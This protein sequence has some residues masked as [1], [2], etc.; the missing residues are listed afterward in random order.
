[1]LILILNINVSQ[2][3]TYFEMISS[4]LKYDQFF[5]HSTNCCKIQNI[6]LPFQNSSSHS[7][8]SFQIS[9]SSVAVLQHPID[10]KAIYRLKVAENTEIAASS[11]QFSL[12]R[13]YQI[14]YNHSPFRS[15]N[16]TCRI[17]LLSKFFI[18]I[19]FNND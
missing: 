12:F 17:S 5:L 6:F 2:R 19:T 13:E 10:I 9:L 16:S 4:I 11:I 3:L 18:S 8:S 1:M 14:V 15:F 7:S